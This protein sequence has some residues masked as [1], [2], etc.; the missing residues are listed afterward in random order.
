MRDIKEIEKRYKDPGRIPKR[1][2]RLL[3]KRYFF[4]LILVIAFITNPGESKHKEAVSKKVNSIVLPPAP[5][6]LEYAGNHPYVDQLVNTHVYRSN[7]YLF[8][9]T[10][11][12][13]DN[14]VITIG[15]GLFGYV[16]LS[17]MIDNDIEQWADKR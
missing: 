16:F 6:G 17:D 11:V 12:S 10:K 1:G 14:Q 8:S 3:K 2:S 9:T 7:Y 13:W 5:S 4:F 15:L